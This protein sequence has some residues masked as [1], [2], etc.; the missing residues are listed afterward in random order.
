MQSEASYWLISVNYPRNEKQKRSWANQPGDLEMLELQRVTRRWRH[1][2]ARVVLSLTSQRKKDPT[3][4]YW[5]DALQWQKRGR[6]ADA[7]DIFKKAEQK[8]HIEEN[9]PYSKSTWRNCSK[10]AGTEQV[11]LTVPKSC[12]LTVKVLQDVPAW[13]LCSPSFLLCDRLVSIVQEAQF[14]GEEAGV[15]SQLAPRQLP[16]VRSLHWVRVEDRERRV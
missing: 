12:L 10:S 4:A 3:L 13:Q 7:G 14:A 2:A 15:A 11:I 16:P 5:L 1:N 9:Q 8:E 6:K